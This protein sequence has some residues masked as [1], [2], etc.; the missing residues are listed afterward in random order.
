LES[1]FLMS[2]KKIR[3]KPS[4]SSPVLLTGPTCAANIVE[5]IAYRT[6]AGSFEQRVCRLRSV[7]LLSFHSVPRGRILRPNADQ[8]LCTRHKIPSG[9]LGLAMQ[10]LPQAVIDERT[11]AEPTTTDRQC[12]SVAT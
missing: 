8:W 3:I 12:F 11:A 9:A 10:I 4:L 2:S 6:E 5:S 7:H 1:T